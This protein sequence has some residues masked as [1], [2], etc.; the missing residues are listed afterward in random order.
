MPVT[1]TT[2]DQVKRLHSDVYVDLRNN[3]G[4]TINA[5]TFV[6]VSG[7]YASGEIPT[8]TSITS[9]SDIPVAMLLGNLSNSKSTSFPS[10]STRAVSRGR[11][12]VV[13]FD[14]TLS[15]V[16]SPVYI[17]SSGQLT[18]LPVGKQ[19]GIV[20]SL[21]VDGV[22][23]IDLYQYSI[24]SDSSWIKY[25]F[26]YSDFAIANN[27]NSINL[28]TLQPKESI[29]QVR[30]KHSVAFSGGTITGYKISVGV[31]GDE[32]RYASGFDVFQSVTDSA[33]SRSLIH[34]DESITLSTPVLI[35]AESFGD[36]L[37]AATAGS[38]EIQI[39]KGF[40]L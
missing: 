13:G 23:Y 30:I 17:N 24:S 33:K 4:S 15:T 37:S 6:K 8:I 20:L 1:Q 18:L 19:V 2:K 34:S 35:T 36:L 21:A 9:V 10:S 38:V 27:T 22:I 25:I 39:S 40:L 29:E 26:N 12:E 5:Y 32:N 3:T 31:S 16:M 28:F 14:T 11:V 7:D